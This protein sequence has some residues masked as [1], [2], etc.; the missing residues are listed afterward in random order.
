M[1]FCEMF[2][3]AVKLFMVRLKVLCRTEW[4][5]KCNKVHD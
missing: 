3:P 4:A 5:V 1:S 2:S